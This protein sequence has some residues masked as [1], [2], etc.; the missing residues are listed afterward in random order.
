MVPKFDSGNSQASTAKDIPDGLEVVPS[1]QSDKQ[2]VQAEKE[3]SHLEEDFSIP[4]ERAHGDADYMTSKEN[5]EMS[6][7]PKYSPPRHRTVCGMRLKVLF[8]LLA[9]VTLFVLGLAIGLGVGLSLKDS[10]EVS[11]EPSNNASSS[12]PIQ[13]AF[14]IGGGLNDSYYSSKGAWNG[15]GLAYTWQTFSIDQ[16]DQ[17]KDEAVMYYQHYSGALRWMRRLDSARW[18]RGPEQVEVVAVD[19]KNATPISAMYLIQNQ[20]SLWHVFCEHRILAAH[21]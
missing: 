4:I 13:E 9:V 2:V 16:E 1:T 15:S 14:S 5:V 11:S 17:P 8:I 21:Q 3:V 19:A 12:P 10:G 18:L 7:G 20:T 6:Q